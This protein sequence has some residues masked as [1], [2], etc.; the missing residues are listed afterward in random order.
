MLR[1]LLIDSQMYPFMDWCVGMFH[2]ASGVQTV[3]VSSEGAGYIPRGVF[4]PRSARSLF[5]DTSLG[6][7]FRA[8]WF[9][10]ANPAETML[11][12]ADLVHKNNP[13]AQLWALAVSTDVGGSSAPA[14]L[15]DIP[16]YDEEH[17]D[18][19]RDSAGVPS[20]LDD[21]HLHRLET[22]D[23]AA[24]LRLTGFGDGPLPDQSEAWR[25]TQAAAHT[26][27]RR[28][29]ALPHITV[30]PAIR[31]VLEL[32]N[33][34]MPVPD[35]QWQ[36]LTEAS[37]LTVLTGSGLRPGLMANSGWARPDVHA[38]HDLSLLI[39]MLLLWDLE[40]SP[41]GPTIKYPDIDY[42]ARQIEHTPAGVSVE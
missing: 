19:A 5:A 34:G 17:R 41:D 1:Q 10:W 8:R 4:L 14:R 3:I 22:L 27:L 6:A 24:Y 36:K 29:G 31:S 39:E 23:R 20:P 18:A 11:A 12:Y 2:T 13:D 15:A 7:Q 32:L 25:T 9:S 37:Y 26:A 42:L 38:Y 33:K 40:H 16:H 35:E 30:P 21:S 28:A